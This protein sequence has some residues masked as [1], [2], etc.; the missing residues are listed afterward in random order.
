[1]Y[2]EV[3]LE[4][5]TSPV[6]NTSSKIGK[7]ETPHELQTIPIMDPTEKEFWERLGSME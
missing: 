3:M 6:S 2:S 7:V 1:M 4:S 5:I